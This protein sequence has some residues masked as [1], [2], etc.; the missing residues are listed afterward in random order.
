MIL[1]INAGFYNT[2]VSVDN[3]TTLFES[4]CQLNA[5][6]ERT[7][8]AADGI[9]EVGAGYRSLDDKTDNK[10]H[11]LCTE[12]AILKYAHAPA[13]N[14]MVA[15]PLQYYLNRE[16]RERYR[17]GMIKD[18]RGIVD[19]QDRSVKVLDCQVYAEGAAAYLNYKKRFSDKTVGILDFG[20]NTI[21]CMVFDH[22]KLVKDTI[23][24][25]DLGMIKLERAIIDAI[26]I[27]KLINV[28]EYELREI[29][30]IKEYQPI[31]NRVTAH[32]VSEVRQRLIAK[33]WNVDRMAIFCTGG[34]AEQLGVE[35]C[36]TFNHCEISENGL[37]D[38]VLGLEAAG[39]ILY[40][41]E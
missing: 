33:Q 41:G 35:L 21:N 15:L 11:K 18:H 6:G 2:K 17:A 13:V 9:Y 12:Y 26:N 38:N 28:Q 27:E 10:T 36:K 24:T 20:G 8:L 14:L 34:G 31:I 4:K 7:I 25:L 16:Y 5:D 40:E 39:K 1:A 32:H 30:E 29:M 19:G 22:G 37:Y 3:T 23:S